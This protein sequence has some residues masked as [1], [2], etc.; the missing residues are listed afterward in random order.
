[1]FVERFGALGRGAA[2]LFAFA[3]RVFLERDLGEIGREVI[4][5]VLGPALEGMVVALVAVEP[6]S[7]KQVRGVLHRLRR[8]ADN[9]P[10]TGRRVLAGGA[11]RGENLA[12]ELVVRRVLLDLFANPGAEQ[13]G[14]FTAQKFAVAL[15]QVGP[16][17]GPKI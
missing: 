15:Q 5:L 7:Q 10:I 12:G 8:S 17:V 4:I 2:N 9:L 6:R 14:A 1:D 13:F 16:F 3:G 11:G